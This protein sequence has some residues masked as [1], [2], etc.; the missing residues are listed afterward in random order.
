MGRKFSWQVVKAY[1]RTIMR[2][3]IT[4]MFFNSKIEGKTATP[5]WSTSI[6]ENDI[7]SYKLGVSQLIDSLTL[8]VCIDKE[9]L[10]L[11]GGSDSCDLLYF[12]VFDQV[13]VNGILL[14]DISY[15]I[16]LVREHSNSHEGR[17]RLCYPPYAKYTKKDGTIV[18]NENSNKEIAKSI[19]CT[20]N[21]CWF[22]YDIS[23]VNQH[24]LNFDTKVVNNSEPV[25]YKGESKDRSAIWN[26]MLSEN[27]DI[28][29]EKK[30]GEIL[31]QMY[32]T[33]DT[34]FQ[35]ASIYVFGV[36][37]GKY[38]SGCSLKNIIQFADL[39]SSFESELSKAYKLYQSISKN[40]YN[41][42]CINKN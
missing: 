16:Y 36:K 33:A 2:V 28:P 22:V 3:D 10:D 25:I 21:G 29:S 42:L 34:G 32:K 27:N 9:H 7:R 40:K 38:L 11:S 1:I 23:V 31:G 41:P 37:Y 24:T 8:N 35:V 26:G 4:S 13:S 20:P 18:W 15:I 14:P 19:G 5:A 17:I 12:C 39:S 30:L 6:G